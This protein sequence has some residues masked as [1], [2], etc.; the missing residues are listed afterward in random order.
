MYVHL[1]FCDMVP[2]FRG[3]TVTVT[4]TAS[5]GQSV[6]YCR[7]SYAPWGSGRRSGSLRRPRVSYPA[8][9]PL[10]TA[11]TPFGLGLDVRRIMYR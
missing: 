1:Y 11:K 2:A 7:I 4:V 9:A 8:F 5:A 3:V 10:V 6:P